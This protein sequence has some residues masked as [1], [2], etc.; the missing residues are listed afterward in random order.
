MI[1]RKVKRIDPTRTGLLQRQFLREINKRFAWLYLEIRKLLVDEDAFGLKERTPLVLMQMPGEFAFQTSP[2]K[3]KTFQRWLKQQVDAGVLE[4][5]GEGVP[6]KPWTYPYVQSAY[7][8]GVTRAYM[9]TN[10]Q[11]LATSPEWYLGSRAQFIQTTLNQ[12]AF[13]S[14]VTLLGTRSFEQLRGISA[15]MSQQL[16]RVMAMGI[17]HGWGPLKIASDMKKTIAGLSI[18]RAR[19]I[20]RT[21]IVNAH[22]IGQLNA[23]RLLGVEELGIMAEWSTAGDERVCSECGELEGQTFTIDEAEGMIPLHP[24]CRCAWIPS[25]ATK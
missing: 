20:A 9:D 21:E 14:M 1:K 23:F 12:P 22:A 13:M 17:A 15:T 4:V 2:Q 5:Y 25:E 19:M 10:K 8:V 18:S 24:N 16:N 7:R 3:L 11:A 6:D